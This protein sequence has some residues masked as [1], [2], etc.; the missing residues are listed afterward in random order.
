MLKRIR[1]TLEQLDIG[2]GATTDNDWSYLWGMQ[3]CLI[4]FFSMMIG[5][6]LYFD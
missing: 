6:I 4:D 5:N 2:V 3:T 1:K